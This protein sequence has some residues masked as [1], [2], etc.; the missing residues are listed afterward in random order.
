MRR[1]F[2]LHAEHE[3]VTHTVQDLNAR[4]WRTKSWTTRAGHIREGVAWTKC[5]LRKLL[6]NPTYIGRVKL[7]GE[8]FDGEHPAIVDPDVFEHAQELLARGTRKRGKSEGGLPSN[9]LLA[10]L[11][12][13]APCNAAM[14]PGYTR[15][16]KKVYRYYLCRTA[17]KENWA[18]CPHPSV[19]THEIEAL[20]IEQ[21]R[22]I[23]RDA[24]LQARV[25]DAVREQDPEVDA[26]RPPSRPHPLRSG[27]GGPPRPGTGPHPEAPRRGHQLRRG[28]GDGGRGLP[29]RRDPGPG[30][31]DPGMS[32]EVT[33]RIPPR[34]GARRRGAA[35]GAP[36]AAGGPDAP[37]S[38][39]PE[40]IPRVARVLA[41]AHHWR[42]LIQS[43]AVRDQAG[44]RA[45]RRRVA[46]AGDAGHAAS[47][48]RAG[49]PGSGID[50]QHPGHASAWGEGL[51]G[52]LRA[53]FMGRAAQVP[54]GPVCVSEGCSPG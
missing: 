47:G 12:R 46:G 16:G 2:A 17:Q 43:G 48:P 45:A 52:S 23:G 38:P 44:P 36:V 41:L 40:R 33:I 19:R 53:R 28:G 8:V 3:T 11:L 30:R 20:V 4:G 37:P 31:G 29:R 14:T 18:A 10:G 15:R 26:R 51:T 39:P 49:H 6:A 5:T 32:A 7:K 1:I 27:V 34:R 42:G 9:A 22:A 35:V 13:C 54:A 24:K 21:I 25:L 50:S